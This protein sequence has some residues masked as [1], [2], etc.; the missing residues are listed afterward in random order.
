MKGRTIIQYVLIVGLFSVLLPAVALAGGLFLTEIS[1][2]EVGLA[3]AGWAARAQNA[4]TVF[5]NPAGMTRF[6]KSELETG[7]EPIYL[8]VKFNADSDTTV[9][10]KNGD[11]SGWMPAGGT[12][13]VHSFTPE[14]KMGLGVFG[15]F[16]LALDFNDKWVGRYLS[17]EEKLQ[18]MSIMPA[19]AYKVN[20]WLSIGG[21]MNF[22]YG[23]FKTK[24][25][26]N[27]IPEGLSDGSLELKDNTWGIGYTLG[28]MVEPTKRTRFGVTYLSEVK[29]N[30][31][32]SPKI[33]GAGP[34][35]GDLLGRIHSLDLGMTVPQGVTGSFYHE[36]N[37]QWALMG[38]VGWQQ[39]SKFGKV[40][41]SVEAVRAGKS[42]TTSA[43]FKDTWHGALGVQFRPTNP[44]LLSLG[45]S[46]DSSMVEDKDRS[47][48]LPVGAA[49]KFGTGARYRIKE[50]LDLGMAYEFAWGGDMP[51]KDV[52]RP[53]GG[54][55]SGQYENAYFHF[56]NLELTWKF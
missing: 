49:W 24:M 29:L 8:N 23:M 33:D 38:N 13:L 21:G 6:S 16:G 32:T 3:S 55:V 41:V 30:F 10:G 47:L 28:V 31:E 34:I 11:A 54:R 37:D 39:W 2:P 48:I 14:F 9:S 51:V 35:L 52:I 18:G 12:F 22:M 27:N 4:S 56:I 53:D 43:P 26:I 5:S 19:A 20:D 45:V 15:Y 46:Y 42:A 44:L 25:A 1:G 7:L 17:K 50:N 40:D 36:F